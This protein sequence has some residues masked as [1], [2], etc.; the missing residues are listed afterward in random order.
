MGVTALYSEHKPGKENMKP[1]G[2][3]PVEEQSHGERAEA[4]Q[5]GLEFLTPSS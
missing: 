4:G 2:F 5:P 1:A 3:T